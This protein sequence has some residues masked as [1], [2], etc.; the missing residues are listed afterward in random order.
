MVLI[1]AGGVKPRQC[2]KSGICP[3][4]NAP[5]PGK[6]TRPA[7]GNIP[8]PLTVTPAEGGIQCPCL[9]ANPLKVAGFQLSLE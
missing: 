6:V 4:E 5:F 8:H 7:D 1:N 3:G 2:T 9:P